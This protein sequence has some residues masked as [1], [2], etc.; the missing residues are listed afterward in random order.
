[1]LYFKHWNLC[2]TARN[3]FP[4]SFHLFSL[5]F[6]DFP[7][8]LTGFLLLFFPKHSI[9]GDTTGSSL[10]FHSHHSDTV[11]EGYRCYLQSLFHIKQ[12]C[13]CCIRKVKSSGLAFPS[14]ENAKNT[15]RTEPLA[16]VST[17]FH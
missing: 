15:S 6:S 2:H 9:K 8:G 11:T 3:F 17:S 10:S 5:S 16:R 4:S 13:S 7:S 14:H 1:M 12:T